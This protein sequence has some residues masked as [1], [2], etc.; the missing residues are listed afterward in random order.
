MEGFN[1][2]EISAVMEN[3]A[4][5]KWQEK[6]DSYHTLSIEHA[7]EQAGKYVR[8]R[9]K[10]RGKQQEEEFNPITLA[11]EIIDKYTFVIEEQSRT[12]FVY[13]ADEGR[14]IDRAEEVIKRE[15]AATLDEE[16][17]AHYYNDVFFFINATAPIKAMC[18]QPELLLC[19]N[20]I[21]NVLTGELNDFTPNVFLT[22]KFQ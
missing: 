2:S 18:N 7:R 5:G 21:L 3:C 13:D 11:K 20:G 1:D 10:Q 6:G 17:R 19:K 22:N 4:L 12:L 15:M 8:E 14:Y 16:T 9:K